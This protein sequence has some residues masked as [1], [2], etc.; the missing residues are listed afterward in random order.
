M[1][2]MED[3]TPSHQGEICCSPF[4]FFFS[5]GDLSKK[6]MRRRNSASSS[7]HISLTYL[8]LINMYLIQTRMGN[9]AIGYR[10]RQ[11]GNE[12]A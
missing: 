12:A 1:A 5:R 8:H 6:I 7:S 10:N 9:S 3:R 4:F 2:T 11:R